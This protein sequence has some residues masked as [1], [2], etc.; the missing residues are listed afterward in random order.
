ML[1]K[2]IVFELKSTYK[3]FTLLFGAE[4]LLAWALGFATNINILNGAVRYTDRDTLFLSTFIGLLTAGIFLAILVMLFA[5][6]VQRF[7]KNLLGEQ[8]YLMHTLPVHTWQLVLSKLLAFTIYALCFVLVMGLSSFTFLVG[9][10][11]F[12]EF[13]QALDWEK[14]ILF[15]KSMCTYNSVILGFTVFLKGIQFLLLLCLADSLGNIFPTHRRIATVMAY[16][17]LGYVIP[18]FLPF[19]SSFNLI[20]YYGVQSF[21][22]FFAPTLNNLFLTTLVTNIIYFAAIVYILHNHLNLE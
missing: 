5:S 20:V 2:L 8:G 3:M 6:S 15:F 18:Y 9:T 13:W 12:S 14:V 10:G 1:R 21:S 11:H 17:L 19:P 22:P 4:I 7:H 16:V